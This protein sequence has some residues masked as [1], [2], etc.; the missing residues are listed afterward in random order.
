MAFC[1]K[2]GCNASQNLEKAHCLFTEERDHQNL[3]A[4]IYLGLMHQHVIGARKDYTKAMDLF[5]KQ[6][7]IVAHWHRN[8][9]DILAIE[10]YIFYGF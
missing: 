2:N 6:P 4:S 10:Y 7:G 9:K 3:E 1:Y 8:K 5:E